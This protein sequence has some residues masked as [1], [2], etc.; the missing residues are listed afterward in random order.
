[1]PVLAPKD[2]QVQ[3]YANWN[4][5]VNGFAKNL[6]QIY[7]GTAGYFIVVMAAFNCILLFPFWAVWFAPEHAAAGLVLIITFQA[8]AANVFGYSFSRACMNII[9]YP[10]AI[11]SLN[12][13][14][15][16]VLTKHF[17][18]KILWKG[19]FVHHSLRS[20]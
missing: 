9:L 4:E 18:K 7:G 13:F 12:F 14:A 15:V 19:R 6:I 3:M 16:Q 2:M 1:M 17:K 5:M 20:H 8:L 10:L 11:L